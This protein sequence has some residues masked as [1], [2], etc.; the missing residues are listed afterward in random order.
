VVDMATLIT[1]ALSDPPKRLLRV[2]NWVLYTWQRKGIISAVSMEM[3]SRARYDKALT[4]L[5]DGQRNLIVDLA[6]RGIISHADDVLTID[7]C[8]NV[9]P[10]IVKL[11]LEDTENPLEGLNLLEDFVA[12]FPQVREDDEMRE[13]LVKALQEL[14]A[15][16]PDTLSK[17]AIAS[18]MRAL[19]FTPARQR[20]D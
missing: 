13:L 4:A 5:S 14:L 10:K 3:L 8:R 1:L 11:Y 12:S 2:V 15:Q 19:I 17:A 7:R 20:G 16:S 18:L 9:L 6:L